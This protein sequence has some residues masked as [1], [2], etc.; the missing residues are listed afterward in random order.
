MS[1]TFER[2]VGAAMDVKELEYIAALL[3]TEH[4][5]QE[6]FRDASIDGKMKVRRLHDNLSAAFT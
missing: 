1:S 2:P 4:N 6:T 3:Q 5:V